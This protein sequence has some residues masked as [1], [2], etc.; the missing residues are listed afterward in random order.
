MFLTPELATV[1]IK[2]PLRHAPRTYRK[3]YM[4][5]LVILVDPLTVFGVRLSEPPVVVVSLN[6][7][8]ARPPLTLEIFAHKVLEGAVILE[9]LLL[10]R[11]LV[12]TDRKEL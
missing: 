11:L 12:R 3:P 2:T 8:D 7:L 9:H 1:F 5:R 4:V 10:T 6:L